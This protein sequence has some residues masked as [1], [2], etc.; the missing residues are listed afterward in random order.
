[1]RLLLLALAVFPVLAA[2]EPLVLAAGKTVTVVDAADPSLRVVLTA[3]A[4]A[5]LDLGALFAASDPKAGV[6]SLVT[7]SQV[8]AAGTLIRDADGTLSL[9]PVVPASAGTAI[10]GGFLVLREGQYSLQ[11][12]PPVAPRVAATPVPE[13]LQQREE[14]HVRRFG[15]VLSMPPFVPAM[16]PPLFNSGRM[17]IGEPDR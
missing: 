10:E 5:P 3:P 1:M 7:R 16:R 6:H 14:L 2:A 17:V 13:F 12:A 15:N 4:E 8:R 9:A 11:A